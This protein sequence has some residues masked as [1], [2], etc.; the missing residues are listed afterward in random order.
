VTIFRL[1]TTLVTRLVLNLRERAV[2]QL[3]ITVETVGR[4]EA[5]LPVARQSLSMTSVQIPSLVRQNRPTV[6]TIAT[7]DVT[8][9]VAVGETRSQQ[10]RGRDA[11]E[12]ETVQRPQ[13]TLSVGR[14]QPATSASVRSLFSAI[15]NRSTGE[16]VFVGTTGGSRRNADEIGYETERKFQAVRLDSRQPMTPT[17]I[18]SPSSVRHNRL[19]SETTSI[20]STGAFHS[21]IQSTDDTIRYVPLR[22]V[23]N[24][25]PNRT[26]LGKRHRNL[27]LGDQA[28]P[29]QRQY[30]WHSFVH[31][32]HKCM[33]P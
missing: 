9:S 13:A 2:K 11:I 4:F 12:Y 31:W 16:T 28:A 25:L 20:G 6:T 18:R 7:R 17:S 30:V 29:L 32:K 23:P 8:A 24:R 22:A 3:P 19:T 15:Q 27:G 14:Q 10:F 21:Q 26:L 33:I 1:S 5:A